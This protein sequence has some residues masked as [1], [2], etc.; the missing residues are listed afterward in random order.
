MDPVEFVLENSIIGD[1]QRSLVNWI[2]ISRARARRGIE[3]EREPVEAGVAREEGGTRRDARRDRSLSLP[4]SLDQPA[5]SLLSLPRW[6][7][8]LDLFFLALSFPRILTLL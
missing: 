1:S 8:L 5:A 7:H 2:R 4:R 3:R 6:V